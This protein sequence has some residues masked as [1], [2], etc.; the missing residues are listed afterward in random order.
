[1]ILERTKV[2]VSNHGFVSMNV[3]APDVVISGFSGFGVEEETER[4]SSVPEGSPLTHA[5]SNLNRSSRFARPGRHAGREI[6]HRA[7]IMTTQPFRCS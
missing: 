1:L 3:K 5:F 7:G 6:D 2:L 4:K